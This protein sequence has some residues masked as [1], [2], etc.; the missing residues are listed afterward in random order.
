MKMWRIW[1]LVYFELYIW[2]FTSGNTLNSKGYDILLHDHLL[3][4]YLVTSRPAASEHD[5]INVTTDIALNQIRELNEPKRF[6]QTVVWFRFYWTDF[7][8]QWEPQDYGNL[9]E[10]RFMK[11]EI[12]VPDIM[13]YNNADEHRSSIQL[14]SDVLITSYHTGYTIWL[15]PGVVKTSCQI[16]MTFYPFDTQQCEIQIGSWSYHGFQLDLHLKNPTGDKYNFLEHGE[17]DFVAFPA[18][19]NVIYYG[20]CPEPYVDATFTAILRRKSMFYIYNLI[21]PCTLVLVVSMSGFL[22]PIESG[23]RAQLSVMLLLS[24]IVLQLSIASDIPSQ[25]DVIPIVSQ[26]LG[27]ITFIMCCSVIL[28][29]G[30]IA[31][32]FK[33]IHGKE[34]PEVV[35]KIVIQYMGRFVGIKFKSHH[36]FIIENDTRHCR[37]KNNNF[38]LEERNLDDTGKRDSERRHF[39]IE[40][41]ESNEN[42]TATRVFKKELKDIYKMIDHMN[43]DR[44]AKE[45]EQRDLEKCRN[46][47]AKVAVVIDRY[48]LLAEFVGALTASLLIFLNQD[49]NYYLD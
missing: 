22:L 21:L 43:K 8:L 38:N 40:I 23:E 34:V 14:Y 24:M 16:D 47:W 11:S 15:V 31:L 7:R 26:F 18:K 4:D 6:L 33:G 49:R 36:D 37:C 28:S 17:W 10:I 30:S 3:K 27:T 32:H 1:S 12:W 5:L 19:R 2:C 25:S 45:N 29:I 35:Q 48:M 41:I 46:D 9:T 20:C 13:L 42:S 44:Q 39:D